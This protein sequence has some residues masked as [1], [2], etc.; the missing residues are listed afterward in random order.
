[1]MEYSQGELP[2]QI[3]FG[4]KLV[5]SDDECEGDEAMPTT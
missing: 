2:F 1:M 3:K 4:H 5:F